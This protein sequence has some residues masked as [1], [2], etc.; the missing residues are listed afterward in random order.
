MPNKINTT[1][2][3]RP[4]V[5]CVVYILAIIGLTLAVVNGYM[6]IS[7]TTAANAQ[8][9]AAS[10][11]VTPTLDKIAPANSTELTRKTESVCSDS[12]WYAPKS[13]SAIES[14]VYATKDITAFTSSENA[15]LLDAGWMEGLGGLQIS[16]LRDS[17]SD[18]ATISASAQGV[19]TDAS[20]NAP[21]PIQKNLWMGVTRTVPMSGDT[22][23]AN[24]GFSY[25]DL[26][27]QK[28][29]QDRIA[30]GDYLV[31]VQISTTE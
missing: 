14:R 1:L 6:L 4:A 24:T 17:P 28:Q 7:A 10:S 19:L 11:V 5:K 2:L 15:K 3:Q 31:I 12:T 21:K 8:T 20:T 23:F 13:C 30:A 26:A 9:S 25:T 18:T 29:L 22:N 16:T 27:L